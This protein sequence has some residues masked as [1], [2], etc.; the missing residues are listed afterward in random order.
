MRR[1][2]S[3]STR[4]SLDSQEQ[5]S[6]RTP[7]LPPPD[8]HSSSSSVTPRGQGSSNQCAH[9]AA[10]AAAAAAFRAM[11]GGKGAGQAA[12]LAMAPLESVRLTIQPL[13]VTS[14]GPAT[15][16]SCAAADALRALSAGEDTSRTGGMLQPMRHASNTAPEAHNQRA[17]ASAAVTRTSSGSGQ[18]SDDTQSRSS[19]F[20]PRPV[21]QSLSTDMVSG[22]DPTH[23]L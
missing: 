14:R 8:V 11:Y 13:D 21:V 18:S 5:Q 6:G 7:C 3:S 23:C 19:A 2:G 22:H 1:T 4:S 15:G 9:A 10:A 16:A 12:P 17:E 20:A